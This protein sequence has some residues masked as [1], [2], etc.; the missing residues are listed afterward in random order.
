MNT[1][2]AFDSQFDFSVNQSDKSGKLILRGDLTIQVSIPFK[3]VLI[4]VIQ[5]ADRCLINMDELESI[6]LS[7]IQLLYSAYIT[8]ERR[9]KK[10]RLD[11]RCGET[12]YS[13]IKR[14]GYLSK[15]WLFN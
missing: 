5:Q 11:G 4:S 14:S 6:D 3:E 7:C 12:I 15:K 2:T 13:T 10:F 9:N 8:A 1:G